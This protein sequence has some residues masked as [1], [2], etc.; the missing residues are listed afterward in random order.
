M[1][2]RAELEALTGLTPNRRESDQAFA[3]R[4]VKALDDVPDKKY[5]KLSDA[6]QEWAEEATQA[7]NDKDEYPAFPEAEDV[8]ESEDTNEAEAD[9]ENAEE[10]DAGE[11]EDDGENP[12]DEPEDNDMPATHTDD[13]EAP[14][15]RNRASAPARKNA[16]AK[17]GKS[18]GESRGG[19]ATGAKAGRAPK[20]GGGLTYVRELLVKNPDIAVPE[21]AEKVK[22][23][24][25]TV[26]NQTLHTT[27]SGFRQDLRVIQEA[28]LLKRKLV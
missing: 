5:N 23:K 28:G 9:T 27:R 3:E 8:D 15:R 13:D 24:G 21:L 19:K 16:T 11:P 14:R 10:D 6:A 20:A 1:S 17:S 18:D 26:S 22:A 25:F 2:V 7:Y 4:I 12:T